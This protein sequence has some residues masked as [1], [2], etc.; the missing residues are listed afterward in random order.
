MYD[1]VSA[2]SRYVVPVHKRKE[3]DMEELHSIEQAGKRMGGIS[4]ETVQAWLSQG[5]LTRTKVG[6]RT[7]IS[8]KSIVDFI[9]RCNPEKPSTSDVA[10]TSKGGKG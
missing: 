4:K 5:K 1:G 10:A 7:M 8:E 6:A 9:A 3:E 2:L